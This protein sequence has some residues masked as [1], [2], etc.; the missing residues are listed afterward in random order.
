V[1]VD[2]IGIAFY[3][4]HTTFIEHFRLSVTYVKAKYKSVF[5]VA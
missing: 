4:F 2:N 5:L 1:E 3:P